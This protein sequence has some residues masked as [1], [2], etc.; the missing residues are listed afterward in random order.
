MPWEK[1]KKVGLHA[2]GTRIVKNNFSTSM[3]STHYT[4]EQGAPTG[5]KVAFRG[6]PNTV[7]VAGAFKIE[8]ES[9]M[10]EAS[11]SRH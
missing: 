11:M 4:E 9:S 8:A 7:R 3:Y 2:E 1:A 5:Q 10:P 6:G